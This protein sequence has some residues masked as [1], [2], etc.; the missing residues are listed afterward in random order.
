MCDEELK[1]VKS[2]PDF[3]FSR[4]IPLQNLSL[5]D[6]SSAVRALISHQVCCVCCFMF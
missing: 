4:I 6:L 5:L 1:S 2:Q 3:D